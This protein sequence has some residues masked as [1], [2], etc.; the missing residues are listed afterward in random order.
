MSENTQLTIIDRYKQLIE[1]LQK[2]ASI[3]N[4]EQLLEH[5]IKAAT[6]LCSAEQAWLLLADQPNPVLQIEVSTLP[7]DQKKRGMVIPINSTLE[8]WVLDNQK[9]VMISDSRVYDQR[10]GRITNPSNLEIKS[11]LSLP[12]TV[13]DKT[14]GV[15]DVVNKQGGDFSAQDQEILASFTNQVAIYI[16]NTYLFLQSDLVSELVHE[17]HTPLASLNTAIHLLQRSDLPDEK[18][19]RIFGMIGTE[20]TRLSDLTTSFLEYARLESGRAKFNPTRIDLLHLL[21]ECVEIMQLQAESKG[22]KIS[23][24]IEGKPLL[25]SADRVKLKQVILNLLNNAIKYNRPLGTIHITTQRT[26]SVL[27]FSIQ[28]DGQGIPAEYIPFLFDR[29]FRTPENENLYPGTGLGLTICKQIVEAHQGMIEVK[30]AFG[31]GSTFTVRL[32]A[33]QEK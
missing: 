27:S 4:T 3:L 11:I 17:L 29:F 32:P 10:Y 19:G 26:P 1:V 31:Q 22:I 18:R 7:N 16:E 20:F 2:L 28:D 15:L 21:A 12:L 9:P 6:M 30:S 33:I 23:M 25:L 24:Q 5:T 14:L 8:G 13:K